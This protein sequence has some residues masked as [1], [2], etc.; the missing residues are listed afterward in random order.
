MK[1]PGRGILVKVVILALLIYA[2]FM[3]ADSGA[4]RAEGQKVLEE[5]RQQAE[6]LRRENEALQLEIDSANDDEV[7]ASVARERFGLVMPDEKVFYDPGAD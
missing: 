6:T 4:K 7:I 1:Y 3:L 2:L 5:L